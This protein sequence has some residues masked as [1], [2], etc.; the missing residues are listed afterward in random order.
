M[1]A[2]VRTQLIEKRGPMNRHTLPR[3]LFAVLVAGVAAAQP[4]AALP[5]LRA[6]LVDELTL[7]QVSGKYFGANMLV[8]LRLEVTST[9]HT[10]HGSAN[11]TGSLSIQRTGTGFD[12]QVDSR[13]GAAGL[14]PM[15]ASGVGGAS[16]TGADGLQVNGIGQISQIAGDDN[17]MANVTTIRFLPAGAG[18]SDPAGYNGQ[19]SSAAEAGAMTARIT[20]LDGGMQLGV[21]GPGVTLA[22]QFVAG[23]GQ[24][25][26]SAQVAG[27]GMF[28]SNQML[29][30]LMTGTMPTQV[31]HQLG[32][33]QALAGL[34]G[35]GR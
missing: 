6:E 1:H 30:T 26:Q 18:A 28:G 5:P 34:V 10:A 4:A 24:V 22:Q 14:A 33:Q 3:A 11:A 9:L 16:A 21:A 35:L 2:T 29:L 12:V 20:F 13:S 23:G 25:L 27:N 8:G 32:V 31:Q 7:S 19:T 15:P 17:R